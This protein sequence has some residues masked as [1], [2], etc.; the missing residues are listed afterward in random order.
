M[1]TRREL[2]RATLA[3]QFLLERTAMEPVDAVRHLA[4][5][6]AQT[7]QTWYGA[8]QSRLDPFDP[9]DLSDALEDRRLVRATL[10]RGTIHLVAAE[11]ALEWEPLIRPV[12]QRIISGAFN[13]F[14]KDLDV[15][16]V[17]EE[18]RRLLAAK[19]L[20]AAELGR[21]LQER[22]PDRDRLALAMVVRRADPLIQPTPRGLWGRPGQAR[23]TD[24]EDWLGARVAA[25]SSIEELV[26]RYLRAFGPASVMDAQ[27]WCGLTRLG[28]VFERLRPGLV[29]LTDEDGRELFD[30][31]DAPRPA[32]ETAAPPRFLYDYDNVLLSHADRSRFGT[33]NFFE[34]G[35]TMDGPQP[36]CLL[37]DGVVG[38]TWRIDRA[39]GGAVLEVRTFDKVKK[40]ES[41][42]IEAEGRRL[43]AFWA[44]GLE[45]DLR[46]ALAVRS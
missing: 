21:G 1:I 18:G 31:S 46:V 45:H 40:S 29:T 37:I 33:R 15:E 5:L 3:R 16:A 2:N 27:A 35:W 30:L 7:P 36:S 24:L 41:E 42:Q 6:Q 4:G 34:W 12:V 22:W 20:T 11:D 32:A 43:L 44:P 23:L 28:E 39:K 9:R 10:M 13:W 19:P 25:E 8:L 17:A 26:L 14:L 38:G